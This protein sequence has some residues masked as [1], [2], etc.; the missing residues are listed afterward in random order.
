MIVKCRIRIVLLI[1]F[2]AVIASC[3]SDE[4]SFRDKWLTIRPGESRSEDVRVLLGPP[5]VEHPGTW[6]ETWCY[7]PSRLE[8]GCIHFKDDFVFTKDTSLALDPEISSPYSLMDLIRNFG[9]P[10]IIYESI[11]ASDPLGVPV[12]DRW[13]FTYPELGFDVTLRQLP[14]VQPGTAPDPDSHVG[15][16]IFYV[17]ISIDEYR[18]NI[19]SELYGYDVR[20]VPNVDQYLKSILYP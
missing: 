18:T 13:I 14:Y 6:D 15:V 20:E 10:K 11:I 12:V 4:R 2:L 19:P 1:A 9:V 5:A 16:R 17:P 8:A 3:Q 7:R